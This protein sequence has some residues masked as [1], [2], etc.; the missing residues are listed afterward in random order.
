MGCCFRWV[1][2]RHICGTHGTAMS[3]Q[4]GHLEQVF[5][6][7]ASSGASETPMQKGC[8]LCGFPALPAVR[9]ALTD[10]SGSRGLGL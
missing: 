4:P 7:H 8:G 2:S 10:V 3:G 6:V 5:A 9:T 1:P